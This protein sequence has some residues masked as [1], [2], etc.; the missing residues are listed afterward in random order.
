MKR[1]KTLFTLAVLSCLGAYG[2]PLDGLD[3]LGVIPGLVVVHTDKVCCS[4]LHHLERGHTHVS[5]GAIIDAKQR[6]VVVWHRPF[7]HEYFKTI[8][9]IFFDGSY[10]EGKLVYLDPVLGFALIQLKKLPQ[11]ARSLDLETVDQREGVFM[12][13]NYGNPTLAWIAHPA[14]CQ[15]RAGERLPTVQSQRAAKNFTNLLLS[16][17]GKL[18]GCVVRRP[19][20]AGDPMFIPAHYILDVLHALR[21]G[22]TFQPGYIDVLWDK[23]NF[24]QAIDAGL[25]DSEQLKGVKTGGTPRHFVYIVRHDPQNVL[26]PG[27]VVLAVNGAKPGWGL[28]YDA[29]RLGKPVRVDV[30][31]KKKEQTFMLEPRFFPR[32]KEGLVVTEHALVGFVPPS[33]AFFLLP[34]LCCEDRTAYFFKKHQSMYT[35]SLKKRSIIHG[36]KRISHDVDTVEKF[37]QLLHE[38]P[39]LFWSVHR[40]RRQCERAFLQKEENFLPEALR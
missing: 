32:A 7:I 35:N 40:E 39:V 37:A 18:L 2:T 11:G 6:L 13:T 38:E 31:R 4:D 15:R 9:V 8:T 12:Y 25:M 1:L 21:Q 28:M 16:K 26:Q 5:A 29:P 17:K 27:D 3:P 14:R 19:F 34:E 24:R 33:I 23:A 36:V 10:E 30:L 20:C 22:K